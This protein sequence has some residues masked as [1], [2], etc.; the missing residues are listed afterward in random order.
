MNVDLHMHTTCS[1]GVYTPEQ[2]TAMAAERGIRI[3]SITD[4]DTVAAYHDHT[5]ADGVTVIPGIEMSSEYDGEDVHILGLHIDPSAPVL[6]DYCRCFRERRFKR[7]MEIVDKCISLGY[8]LDRK[9]LEERAAQ[10]G[11]VGRPHIARLLVEKGYFSDVHAVFD[12]LLYRNGP[13]YVPY[14]R[15]RIDECITRIHEAK[16]YA[17]LAHPGLLKRTLHDVLRYSFDGLEVYHPNNRG[18]FDE[19]L[20]I[21]KKRKWLVSGGSDFHGTPGRYPERLGD[22]SIQKSQVSDVLVR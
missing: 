14:H 16:G 10:G 2:L 4:H 22:F 15:N 5:F 6:V 3:L 19:F 12:E 20:Q 21:V 18:R 13:A 11:T 9:T 1:D 17:I 7:A 8:D